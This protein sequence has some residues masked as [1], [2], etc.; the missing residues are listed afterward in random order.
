MS[1]D[2]VGYLL[3]LAGVAALYL[4]VGPRHWCEA[5]SAAGWAVLS[6]CASRRGDTLAAALAAAAFALDVYRWWKGGGGS[7][8]RRRLRA[9]A[10]RFRGVRRTAP[11]T[12]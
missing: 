3:V 4:D 11:T 12:A 7:G 6:A 1:W 5:V 10:A 9:L 8:T 2:L